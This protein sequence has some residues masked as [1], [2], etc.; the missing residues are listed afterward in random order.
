MDDD[1]DLPVSRSGVASLQRTEESLGT[2]LVRGG[3]TTGPSE[4]DDMDYHVAAEAVMARNKTDAA[5]IAKAV[6][7]AI[8][9]EQRKAHSMQRKA[10]AA[11]AA[12]AARLHKQKLQEALEA[13]HTLLYEQLQSGALPPPRQTTWSEAV[14][15]SVAEIIPGA[16]SFF[17]KLTALGGEA[18][19]AMA[20]A[21]WSV[22]KEALESRVSAAEV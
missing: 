14:S 21:Q 16:K 5:A 11:Q 17:E 4:D 10:L 12:N 19:A 22:E 1:W 18:A 15:A 6:S 9:E 2:D 3:Y 8:A 13:Q 20:M 7:E